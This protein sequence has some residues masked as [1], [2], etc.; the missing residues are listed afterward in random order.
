L[1]CVSA[2]VAAQFDT[3]RARV[4]YDGLAVD[5]R[6]APRADARVVLGLA[7]D[8]PVIAVL[9]RIS[10]W[11]GQDV[12]VR[13]LAE[14]PLAKI[15]AIGLI[16]GD[17]WPG[18]EDRRDAV[19]GLAQRLGVADRVAFVGFRDD[20]E[21]VYGAADVVAVP[22]TE[23]DPLPNAAL[24]AAAA[25]CAV[26]ASA[27]GGLPEIIRDGVTG[28]LVTPRDPAALA[29]AAAELLGDPAERERLG[30]AAAT[31]VRERF[32]PQRLVAAVQSL[33]DELLSN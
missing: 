3:G 5:A 13:A 33:Y 26:V 24:E 12:L 19:L 27:H 21:N 11:K 31:D 20:V 2:A 29:L 6:P 17:A 9:G 1:P 8:A 25:G 18:A 30:A 14:Q 28:R 10:D 22:S 7:A 16:A 23:P 4:I 15:G 32:A